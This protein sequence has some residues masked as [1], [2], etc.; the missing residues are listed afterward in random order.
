MNSMMTR[1]EEGGIIQL[2]SSYN[3]VASQQSRASKIHVV[4]LPLKCQKP[5]QTKFQ[6]YTKNARKW[7]V[8]G[9]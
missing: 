8:P 3:P 9:R 2:N 6:F 1:H 7:Q 5:S 4:V